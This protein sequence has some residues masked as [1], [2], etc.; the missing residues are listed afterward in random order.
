MSVRQHLFG[1]LYR[2]DSTGRPIRSNHELAR[3]PAC[4]HSLAETSG[5]GRHVRTPTQIGSPMRSTLDIQSPVGSTGTAPLDQSTLTPQPRQ[6]QARESYAIMFK[7]ILSP[8]HEELYLP[9]LLAIS[10][11]LTL[12]PLGKSPSHLGILRIHFHLLSFPDILTGGIIPPL[13]RE[14]S[15]SPST[16]RLAP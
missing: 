3:I 8:R 16:S 1:W 4:G 11:R 12:C 10:G 5:R 13:A 6:S 9:I 15:V 2:S 14:I 7:S